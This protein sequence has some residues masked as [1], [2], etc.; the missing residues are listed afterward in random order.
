MNVLDKAKRQF[1]DF[2]KP[3]VNR[4]VKSMIETVASSDSDV[5]VSIEE[6]N[7]QLFISLSS[8]RYLSD[9][10]NSNS[11]PKSSD[12]D[13]SDDTYRQLITTMAF[14]PKQI[15]KTIY[16]LLDIFW[17]PLLSRANLNNTVVGPFNI[18]NN[19]FLTGSVTFSE[20]SDQVSGVGTQ[21]LSEISIGDYIKPNAP[22]TPGYLRVD[23]IVDDTSLVL[24]KRY[25]G[26]TY[27]GSTAR[28]RPAT[29]EIITDLGQTTLILD[30]TYFTDL[31]S[32]TSTELSNFI[33]SVADIVTAS[34]NVDLINLRTNTTGM[35][36]KI[37]VV[38]GTLNVVLGFSTTESTYY[39]LAPVASV[40]EINP[41]E[42]II[43]IP[44]TVITTYDYE[45][46]SAHI[47]G[48]DHCTITS[49]D[50]ILKT[51]EVDFDYAVSN[52]L[53]DGTTLSQGINEF[54]IVSHSAGTLGVVLNMEDVDLSSLSNGEA[55]CLDQDY[56]G[57]YFYDTLSPFTIKSGRTLLSS[58]IISGSSITAIEVEDSST[59]PNEPG[60][61]VIG[62][63]DNSEE[64][65]VRY[66]GIADATHLTIDPSYIFV[67]G[68]SAGSDV[69]FMVKGFE[70]LSL[71][72]EDYP[73]FLRDYEAARRYF[74]TLIESVTA[75]GTRIRWI[76]DENEYFFSDLDN[77]IVL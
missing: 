12:F 32:V 37:Q 71:N 42:I 5:E 4:F 67:N 26:T 58:P 34:D 74:Q 65:K 8:G 72:G 77:T 13:V 41:N 23:R 46:G 69:S 16:D 7:K 29:L 27:V 40:F 33:N 49:I 50:N 68:H 76:L 45:M 35:K 18:S 44:S 63:G 36:G 9:L 25:E 30:P 64:T 39:D 59:F 1:P 2:Y 14:A 22:L 47:K 15:R 52:G 57:S 10:G 3:N 17:G 61:L 48:L 11:V 19:I 60:D 62:F 24:S 6:A 31:T 51:V 20:S 75:A 43:K 53:F 21:F 28:N 66:L 56:K 73:I 38:G 70:S 54:T 55:Y